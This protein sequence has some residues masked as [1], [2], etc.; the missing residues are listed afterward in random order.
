LADRLIGAD[1]TELAADA[2]RL[3]SVI[4]PATPAAPGGSADGGPQGLPPQ[5][6][7]LDEQIT[8]ARASGNTALAISLNNQKLA[9][10]A[11]PQ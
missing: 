1:E 7:S 6:K 4:K 10:L 8:E 2:D 9:A 11:V 5:P 3:L